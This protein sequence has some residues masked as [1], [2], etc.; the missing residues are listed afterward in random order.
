MSFKLGTALFELDI[1]SFEHNI[2][3][4]STRTVSVQQTIILKAIATLSQE[5]VEVWSPNSGTIGLGNQSP[6]LN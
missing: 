2:F 1:V 6:T 4:L 5:Y 3:V